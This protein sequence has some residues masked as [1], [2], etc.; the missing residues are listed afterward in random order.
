MSYIAKTSFMVTALIFFGSGCSSQD[1]SGQSGLIDRN[2]AVAGQFYSADPAR[3]KADLSVL[4]A[5]AVP[6]QTDN[7]MAILSPHAGYVFSGE[8]AASAFNQVDPEK[9]YENIFILASSHRMAFEG[10]SIYDRGNYITPLGKVNVNLEL[11]KELVEKHPVFSD[12][13]DAHIHEHSLEVQLPFLQYH[14]QKDF[15]IIPII[16]GTQSKATCKQ[17][18]E[19][20]K[21]YFN[22]KNLFVISTDFSHYPDYD[23]AVIVD[24]LTAEA[25]LKNSP[26]AL[27]EALEKNERKRIPNLATSLCG[28]TSVMSLL[29]MTEGRDDLVFK[30]IQYQNSGDAELY[31]DKDRVVGYY[32]I[33]VEKRKNNPQSNE[34]SLT[35]EE[36]EVLMHIARSTVETYIRTGK[37]TDI[38]ERK[39][40]DK[41]RQPM[42]A[43]V[44][45]KKDGQ[46]RGCIGRFDATEPLYR[47]VEAMAVSAALHD[48]RFMPV[49]EEELKE[50]EIEI[51]VL[52][53]MRRIY[54]I[55]EL[56]LGKH[57]IY[58]KKGYATGTFLP[59]VAVETGWTKEEFL[60][61]CARDKARIGW[62]GWKDAELYVYEAYIFEEHELK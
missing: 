43:F 62:D 53:P 59:Q 31:G 14:L 26:D 50:I 20:L 8:V 47:V 24:N 12:R 40:T 27:S 7:V 5:N 28:W 38:D 44:T 6:R 18:G 57:G 10:A 35:K 34:F 51:S 42:G 55:D 2:P 61:R 39:L 29:Y 21:P 60:G 3:L 1:K 9:E 4:F 30:S 22:E 54:S 37:L 41:I 58:I 17:I 48:S 46:L 56:E 45:L 11:A 32:A 15:T 23:D 25:I 13:A 52:T 19:A 33:A 49:S 16:L 36:K